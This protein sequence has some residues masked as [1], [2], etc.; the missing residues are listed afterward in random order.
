MV[1]PVK[2]RYRPHCKVDTS[3]EVYLS[4]E[5]AHSKIKHQI[6]AQRLGRIIQSKS[7]K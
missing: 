2:K 7:K 5:A 3:A 1:L 4:S 6:E